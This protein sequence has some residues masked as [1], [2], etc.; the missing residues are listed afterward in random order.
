MRIGRWRAAVGLAVLAGVVAAGWLASIGSGATAQYPPSDLTRLGAA[1]RLLILAPHPDDETL[2]CGGVIQLA[3]RD[4]ARVGIVWMTS[5]DAF[6]LAAELA[7]HRLQPGVAGMRELGRDRMQEARAAARTLGVAAAD[8]FF[9]GYPDGGLRELTRAHFAA[10]YTSPHTGLQAVAYAGTV[11]PGTSFEGRNLER[12]LGQLI[13]EWKPTYILA[14]SPLDA[15]PDHSATGEFAVHVLSERHALDRLR[16]WIVH[17]GAFW[18][19]PRG[20]HT[21]EELRPPRVAAALPWQSVALDD[22]A[23]TRKLAALEADR[24]Q[25][26]GLERRFLVA[27]VRRNELFARYATH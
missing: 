1:D 18:P 7:E 11:A 4:G 20:L 6:T 21:Q 12:Q 23:R 27:F 2:C 3:L 17:A 5:G 16:V 13:D 25:M 19:T 26:F 15:H 22:A 9:L 10:P 8:E 24:S 14:P